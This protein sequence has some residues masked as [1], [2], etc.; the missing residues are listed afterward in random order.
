MAILNSSELKCKAN[1]IRNKILEMCIS[2]GGHIVSSLS[3]VDILVSLYYSGALNFD[4][5]NPEWENRDRFILSKG[6]G[7]T[8]LYAVLADLG[9][10]PTNLIEKSY[11][12]GNCFL[13]GHP[14]RKIPGVEV[15]TGS[16]GHGLGLAV[17]I[18]MA[19]KMDKKSHLQFV[20]MGDAEC[21]EGSVWEAALFACKY[22]L[23]NLVGIVDRNYI[24]SLDFTEN[25][26]SLEPFSEKWKSFGWEVLLCNGHDFGELHNAF[27]YARS[28]T[29]NK[30]L[31]IIAATVKGKGVSFMENDPS[32]HVRSL[33]DEGD[34]MRAKEELQWSKGK[35]T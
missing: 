10:F 7:E 8:A 9:F 4:T 20:L 12:Q 13:G 28:R 16:L 32:W 29:S 18:S 5:K 31:V 14:D 1:Q 3:F 24:G 19:A 26:T 23:N 27:Q 21:T 17:G 22:E 25:Y 2:I 15:T 30:P 6:H 34:I 11:R 33:T 35:N